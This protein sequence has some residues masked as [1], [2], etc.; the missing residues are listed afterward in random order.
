MVALPGPFMA[1]DTLVS[2]TMY[3]LIKK[4]SIHFI[5]DMEL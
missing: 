4:L 3:V 1:F 5:K 2:T